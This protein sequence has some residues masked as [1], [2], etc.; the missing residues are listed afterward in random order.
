MWTFE[1]KVG[2]V[3]VGALFDARCAALPSAGYAPEINVA[4]SDLKAQTETWVQRAVDLINYLRVRVELNYL[5]AGLLIFFGLW[6][7]ISLAGEVVEGD[8]RHFDQRLLL[9]LRNPA[10]LSDPLGPLW[11]E[12]VFRDLTA[13][14]GTAILTLV[15]V[16]V[17]VYLLLIQR[18]TMAWLVALSVGGGYVLNM[19]LKA[20]FD[21]PRPDLVPHYT[22]VYYTSFPSG[23]S[24][25]AATVYLTLGVLLARIQQRRRI[26]A[27]VMAM[28]ILV[29]VLVGVSRVYLGVHW[30]TDVVAGWA[31]GAVW[32]TL[33]ALIV[34]RLQIYWTRRRNRAA[35][36]ETTPGEM[37]EMSHERY[38]EPGS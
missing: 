7:F 1:A 24:M 9:A 16:G 11:M 2:V 22:E 8:T 37:P 36:S 29:T 31:A 34:W 13:L 33:S 20:G 21:R 12:E 4:M 23:H 26:A 19:A 6:G 27:F 17:A 3:V 15:T 38:A 35:V 28:A 18:R 5:L 30:P 25:L 14:G 10:D 32:A